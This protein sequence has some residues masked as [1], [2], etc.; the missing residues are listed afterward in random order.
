MDGCIVAYRGHLGAP[1]IA[2]FERMEKRLKFSWK[3][4]L[5]LVTL[6]LSCWENLLGVTLGILDTK[7]WNGPSTLVPNPAT[8]TGLK[9]ER[10]PQ[11]E[12]LNY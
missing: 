12:G 2:V 4:L 7:A 3:P 5:C 6:E 10:N 1:G 11:L 9:L 8:S